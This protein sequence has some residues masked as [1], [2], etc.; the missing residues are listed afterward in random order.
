VNADM[1]MQPISSACSINLRRVISLLISSR[2]P[3]REEA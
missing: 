3:R 1:L 2:I